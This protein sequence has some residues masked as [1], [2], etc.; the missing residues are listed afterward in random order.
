MNIIEISE[1]DID[2]YLYHRRC[3][4]K[5]E[6]Y[7]LLCPKRVRHKKVL[8]SGCATCKKLLE[9]AKQAAAQSGAGIDVIYV[10]DLN[11]I[12]KSGMPGVKEIKQMIEDEK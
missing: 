9:I 7:E 5:E 1:Y 10:T 2:R 11:E 6:Q 3:L 12:M 4:Y 8:G